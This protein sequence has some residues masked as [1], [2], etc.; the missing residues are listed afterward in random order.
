MRKFQMTIMTL[1]AIVVSLLVYVGSTEEEGQVLGEK[2]ES[3]AVEVTFLDIGQ[4]DAT[5]IEFS[6]GQQMLIDCSEDARV[7]EALGRVMEFYD[8]SIDYLVVTHP[9]SDHYGGCIDV[10]KRFDVGHIIY[11]GFQKDTDIHHTFLTTVEEEVS[12]GAEYTQLDAEGIW[13]IASSSVHFLYPD[14]DVVSDAVVPGFTKIDS[15][16]TSIVMKITHGSKDMLLMG[17]ASE[18]LES[19]LMST[20]SDQLDAGVLKVGHHGS[21]SSSHEEFLDFVSPN[22]AAIS[23]GRNNQYGHP[24]LRVLKRLERVGAKVLRTDKIGD[25]LIEMNTNDIYVQEN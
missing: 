20:Y 16:D 3:G 22:I 11:T 14:H 6:D 10:M 25:I 19:Y 1:L 13:K 5:F 7:I 17:D 12:L 23:A 15:N 4:G 9:D 24:S 18:D 21:G 8:K 2:I